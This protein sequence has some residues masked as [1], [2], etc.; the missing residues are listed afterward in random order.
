M[1]TAS[2]AGR[3]K[4]RYFQAASGNH[5]RWMVS[6]MDIVTILLILFVAIAAQSLQHPQR[7]AAASAPAPVKETIAQPRPEPIPQPTVQPTPRPANI[8]LET[9]KKLKQYGLDSQLEPRGL[10]ISLPQAILFASGQDRIGVQAEPVV[11]QI[12]AVLHDIPNRVTLIGHA[13]SIPIHNSRFRNNWELSAA[14]G[15]ALLG[16]LSQKYDIPESR[17]SISSDGSYNPAGPNDTQEG[18]AGNRRVEIVVLD[19]TAAAI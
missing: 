18:R 1:T 4:P 5:E 14:R 11:A 13:D 10:V 3:T 8:L 2:S 9:Q 7:T 15:L 6:Y 17:L 16:I 12:A 19:G